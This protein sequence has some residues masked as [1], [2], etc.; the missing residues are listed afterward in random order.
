MLLSQEY[1][2]QWSLLSKFFFRVVF[3]YIVLYIILM[4]ISHFLEAP[5][6]WIGKSILNINYDYDVSGFGSGD[7]TYA[8]ITLFVNALLTPIIVSIWTFI[9]KKRQSYNQALYWFLIFL[10]VV[11]ILFM[12]L[13]GSVKIYQIQFPQPSLVRLLQPLGE[14]SPMGLAWTYMGYSEGF[15]MFTGFM[16]IL[17]GL[18]LIPRRTQ[19]IGAFIVM[20]VMTHVAVMNF[21]FDIPV[22]LLSTHLVVMAGIIF[23]TDYKRFTNVFFKNKSTEAINYYHP[24][25]DRTYFKAIFWLKTI[26]LAFIIVGVCITGYISERN[27]GHKRE[28]PFLYGIW[29]VSQFIKNKD[30]I[31]PLI[32]DYKRWRYFVLDHKGKVVIKAMSDKKYAYDISIDSTSQQIKLYRELSEF[33]DFNFKYKH[34]NSNY[35]ELEGTLQGDKL[36]I[37]LS[38]KDLNNFNLISRGFNWINERPYNR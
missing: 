9:D 10:R 6:R 28:K 16:E 15:N 37:I 36:K 29:E 27:L 3:T 21:M 30:T 35:L 23:I 33:H 14:F 17:G 7:H 4:F 38:R 25:K 18:L 20:G 31:P 19:T 13:Y 5:F 34:P 2:A 1:K 22:K 8:Y 32:T 12:F 26:A 11:L 24:I